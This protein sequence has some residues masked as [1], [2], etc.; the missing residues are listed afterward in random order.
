LKQLLRQGRT[1][2]IRYGLAYSGGS[3]CLQ[4][5]GDGAAFFLVPADTSE[6]RAELAQ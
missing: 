5:P 2:T 1:V 4:F 3:G 6:V